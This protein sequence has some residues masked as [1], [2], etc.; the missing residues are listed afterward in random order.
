M[1]SAMKYRPLRL[2]LVEECA[3]DGRLFC[4]ALVRF[5]PAMNVAVMGATEAQ[6]EAVERSAPH[7]IVVDMSEWNA[8]GQELIRNL[9][10]TDR[11]R[12][13]PVAVL[14][15]GGDPAETEAIYKAGVNCLIHKPA[16]MAG[17]MEVADAFC[18]IWLRAASLADPLPI[19]IRPSSA[20]KPD[21]GAQP[22]GSGSV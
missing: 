7:L 2:L 12:T 18:R 5:A 4:E 16:D 10:N 19:T 11:T 22:L 14:K 21:G 1:E 13:V 17:M 9:K 8:A 6:L 15:Q 20:S 3:G